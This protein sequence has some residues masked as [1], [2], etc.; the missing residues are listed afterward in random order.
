MV[1][2]F[3]VRYLLFVGCWLFG[4]YL[5]GSVIVLVCLACLFDL[6]CLII[7]LL[8]CGLFICVLTRLSRCFVI[9]LGCCLVCLVLLLCTIL[10]GLRILFSVFLLCCFGLFD[11]GLLFCFD[12]LFYWFGGWV[13]YVVDFGLMFDFLL[14]M[15]LVLCYS[16]VVCS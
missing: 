13:V 14:A 3:V 12:G 15:L 7:V 5:I 8:V 4:D 1:V 11:L 16:C 2:W 9:A 10:F 6:L